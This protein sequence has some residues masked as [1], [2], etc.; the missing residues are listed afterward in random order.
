M[1]TRRNSFLLILT[2][3][4]WGTAFVAQSKGGDVLGAYTFNC[5]R[6]FIGAGILIPVIF[7]LEKLG[8]G[9]RK[10]SSKKEKQTL[11]I[12][13]IFCGV[14][15]CIASNLQQVGITMGTPAGKAGFL[16]ACYIILVP[17]LGIFLK[18]KCGWNIWI[19]VVLTIIGLYLLCMKGSF[20]L[21]KS[22]SLVIL[23]ALAF[24]FHILIIDHFSP[25]VDGVRMSCI[26]FLVCGLLSLIPTIVVEIRTS[27]LGVVS[28]STP[29]TSFPAWSA[30]LYAGVLSSGVAY[31]LQIVGQE[32]VN[33]TVA[34]LLMSLESVFAVLAG[35]VVLHEYM[36]TRELSGCLLIFVAVVLAQV[37]IR[38]P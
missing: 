36:S 10:P 7:L 34:S 23:C 11:W 22:D 16:S 18:K 15:L 26:Q 9:G 31:T 8:F 27:P 17:I 4:I 37:P 35:W 28:W 13:G 3:F 6:S 2:A 12:G 24:S 38:K 19:G 1:K 30:L 21:Q 14:I 32:D 5:V 33:P 29:F 25:L 20:S